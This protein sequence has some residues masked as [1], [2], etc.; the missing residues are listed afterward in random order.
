MHVHLYRSPTLQGLMAKLV[1]RRFDEGWGTWHA[2]VYGIDD[3]VIISGYAYTI[4]PSLRPSDCFIAELIS[5]KAISSIDKIDISY[6]AITSVSQTTVLSFHGYFRRSHIDCFLQTA[7]KPIN[8]R[9]PRPR[10]RLRPLLICLINSFVIFKCHSGS[11]PLLPTTHPP[12]MSNCFQLSNPDLYQ[13]EK[14][15][16]PC[17]HYFMPLGRQSQHR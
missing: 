2:K 8:Y 12:L 5:T 13:Y 15:S 17:R 14:R 7:P 1:P 6:S 10:H 16:L 4:L 9:G 11:P 3:E